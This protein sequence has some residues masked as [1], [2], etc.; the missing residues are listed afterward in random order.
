MPPSQGCAG[1]GAAV[2]ASVGAAVGASV[3]A[4]VGAAV[5]VAVGA[6]VAWQ[7]LSDELMSALRNSYPALHSQ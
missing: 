7:M 4:T 3:G 2:G 1:V 5:G 6:G